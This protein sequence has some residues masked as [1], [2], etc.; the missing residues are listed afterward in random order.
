MHHLLGALQALPAPFGLA[1]FDAWRDPRLQAVLH[2]RVYQDSSLAPGFVAYPR[3]R[4]APVPAACQRRHGRPHA[5]LA[6]VPTGLWEPAS[7]HSSRR[8]PPMRWSRTGPALERDLRRLVAAPWPARV[9][10]SIPRSGGTGS[11]A[12]ATGPAVTGQPVLFGHARAP[13]ALAT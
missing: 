2:D 13:D 3:S 5:H 9:S 7:T 6:R 12:R 1:V 8:P 10:S 11:T 4:S